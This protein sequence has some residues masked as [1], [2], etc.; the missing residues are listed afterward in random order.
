MKA[1][2]PVAAIRVRPVEPRDAAGITVVAADSPGA[3]PWSA[4][5]YQDAAR[6]DYQGWLAEQDTIVVGFVFTRIAADEVE[7]LNLAV[8]PDRR[9]QG[10]AS[11]LIARALEAAKESGAARAY[12]EVRPSNRAAIALYRKHGLAPAGRRA[13]YYSSPVEDALVLSRTVS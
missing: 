9:R 10:I 5:Q 13:C 3:A 11:Q 12:L 6:G 2:I 4:N 8:A 7:I 1:S